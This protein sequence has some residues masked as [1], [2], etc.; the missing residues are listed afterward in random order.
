MSKIRNT[1]TY[2]VKVG[3][4]IVHSGITN[5]LDRRESEHLQRWP[6]SHIFKVGHIKT[7]E[8]ALEWENNQDKSITPEK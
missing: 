6:N 5:D 8:S 2:H 1:Y 7:K 4:K 3:N